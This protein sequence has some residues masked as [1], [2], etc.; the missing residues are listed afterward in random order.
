MVGVICLYSLLAVREART[1]GSIDKGLDV[2]RQS[3]ILPRWEYFG[4]GVADQ[5]QL[6][7]NLV[8]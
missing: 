5:A 6:I 4:I 1:N 7:V 8:K 3:G 2:G